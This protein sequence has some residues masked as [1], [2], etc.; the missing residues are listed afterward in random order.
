MRL[1]EGR[2]LG[3]VLQDG[4]LQPARAV[5]VLDQ[6]ARALQAA[7]DVGLLGTAM[8]NPPTFCSLVETSRI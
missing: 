2:D 3:T 8:S 5:R 1:V 6:V 7:H 4:P